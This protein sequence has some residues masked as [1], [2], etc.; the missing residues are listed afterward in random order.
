MA[1]EKPILVYRQKPNESG[2]LPPVNQCVRVSCHSTCFVDIR[3]VYIASGTHMKGNKLIDAVKAKFGASIPRWA[4]KM[5]TKTCPL[6]IWGSIR[7]THKAG[8]Q[9]IISLGFGSHGQ[10][11]LIDMQSMPDGV[12]KWIMNHTDHGIKI[13]K[14]FSLCS[15]KCRGVA[16][17]LYNLFYFIGPPAILQLDNG[18]EFNGIAL[19][20]KARKE[21]ISDKVRTHALFTYTT[22]YL[23]A[24]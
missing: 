22:F 6:C 19:D 5:F 14:L 7:P 9:P 10:I 12:F 18:G 23:Y 17:H 11:N 16:W 4:C 20:G 1:G 8:H 2:T 24:I 15:K 3:A 13:T 21:Q